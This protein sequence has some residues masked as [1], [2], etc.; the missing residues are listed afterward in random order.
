MEITLKEDEPTAVDRMVDYLYRLDYESGPN[1][2]DLE[3]HNV[4]VVPLE[5]LSIHAHVYAIADKY[6]IW[7][8]GTMA[9]QKTTSDLIVLWRSATFAAALD[10]VWTTTPATNRGLRDLYIRAVLQHKHE[11]HNC[12]PFFETLKANGDL[13]VEVIRTT[14]ETEKA[15]QPSTKEKKQRARLLDCDACG[16]VLRYCKCGVQPL[17]IE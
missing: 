1:K 4:N 8:L 10:V 13:M 15:V 9:I 14:W 7:G 2:F 16:L 17:V 5:P 12:E 11:L 3:L 6:Q